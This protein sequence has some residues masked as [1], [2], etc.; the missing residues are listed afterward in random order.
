MGWTRTVDPATLVAG[1]GTAVL[2]FG[3][4]PSNS[5]IDLT[6]VRNRGLFTITSDQAAASETQRGVVGAVLVSDDAFAAGVG[7]M[8]APISDPD[9]DWLLYEPFSEQFLFGDGTG[10]NSDAER[11]YAYDSKAKRVWQGT[12]YT[13]AFICQS[14]AGSAGLIISMTNSLLVMVRGV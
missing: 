4:V 9:Q 8:P 12:G 6:I 14:Q 1:A 13:L 11:R 7:S 2:L 10:F 5:G 3:L